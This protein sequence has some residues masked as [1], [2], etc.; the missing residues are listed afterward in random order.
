MRPASTARAP[1]RAARYARRF[2][3]ACLRTAGGQSALP[4]D[5][6]PL[7]PW[8]RACNQTAGAC[9]M[10]PY[11]HELGAFIKQTGN[12]AEYEPIG[13]S[14]RR[15]GIPDRLPKAQVFAG[16]AHDRFG[17]LVGQLGDL[18]TSLLL[19]PDRELVAQPGKLS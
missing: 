13:E 11:F 5:R 18:A 19:L 8:R 10:L 4:Y 2:Q 3:P 1:H 16:L 9:T 17:P 12:P 15:D 6:R 14:L 7:D